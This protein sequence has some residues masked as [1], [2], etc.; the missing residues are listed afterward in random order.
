MTPPA[1]TDRSRWHRRRVALMRT[2]VAR[3]PLC[4]LEPDRLARRARS[5]LD[6]VPGEYTV[7]RCPACG[8]WITSPRPTKEDLAEAY[9]AGYHRVSVSRTP[10]RSLPTQGKLLD[11]GCGVGDYLLQAQAAGWDCTGIEIAQEAVEIARAR[12]LN[13]IHGDATDDIYPNTQFDRVVCWHTLEHVP[14]PILLLRRLRDAVKSDGSIDLL[15]PNPQSAQ[16]LLFRR[17]WYHLDLP[18]HLHHFRPRDVAALAEASGLSVV[19]VRHTASPSGLLGSLDILVSRS[20]VRSRLR[21]QGGVRWVTRWL[22]WTIA[23]LRLA[24]VVEYE[25]R[26]NPDGARPPR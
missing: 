20:A 13:V 4:S 26:V 3:C 14:D 11:V 9:P 21:L 10:P 18:R 17:Y 8:M 2:E 15:L 25:L 12:G 23:R 24:D 16:S 1:A 22:T 5:W 6:D 7:R 19:S